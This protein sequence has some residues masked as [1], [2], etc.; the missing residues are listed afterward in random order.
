VNDATERMLGYPIFGYWHFFNSDDAASLMDRNV[1][2][3]YLIE[4]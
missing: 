3:C 1:G 2:Y 4:M